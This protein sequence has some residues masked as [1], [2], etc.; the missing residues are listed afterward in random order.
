MNPNMFRP[1]GAGGV[2]P[3]ARLRDRVAGVARG[4][5]V[6][7]SRVPAGRTAVRG[8]MHSV[9]AVLT[10]T[11]GRYRFAY[12]TRSRDSARAPA[13]RSRWGGLCALRLRAGPDQARSGV[14]E[15]VPYAGSAWARA[16][17]R[18]SLIAH[19]SDPDR[20]ASE[21]FRTRWMIIAWEVWVGGVGRGLRAS[22]SGPGGASRRPTRGTHT[23]H[24][25]PEACVRRRYADRRIAARIRATQ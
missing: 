7:C 8:Y 23:P 2:E 25:P 5:T 12:I 15:G 17:S 21:C 14:G 3:F 11:A 24:G 20:W 9:T 13:G 1:G 19:P 6:S 16:V 18:A 4:A 10:R 22:P